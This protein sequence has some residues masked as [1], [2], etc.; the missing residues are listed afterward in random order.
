[1]TFDHRSDRLER[2]SSSSSLRS[3]SDLARYAVTY[4]RSFKDGYE[5]EEGLRIQ[6]ARRAKTIRGLATCAHHI[7]EI[8]GIKLQLFFL[9][10]F[11]RFIFLIYK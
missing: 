3:F 1:V 5:P 9:I 4:S 10:S 11:D 6:K 2:R 8:E 7:L